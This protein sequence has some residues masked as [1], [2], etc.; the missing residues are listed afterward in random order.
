MRKSMAVLAVLLALAILVLCLSAIGVSAR[1]D[2]VI[3]TEETLYGSP[4]S[5]G[6]LRLQ[7]TSAYDDH[8]LWETVFH[9]AEAEAAQT[10]FQFV[11]DLEQEDTDF[12]AFVYVEVGVLNYSMHFN[13]GLAEL[14]AME[15]GED[16]HSAVDYALMLKPAID[17]ASRTAAG[18]TRKETL[19]LRDYYEYY[20]VGAESHIAGALSS[21]IL[22]DADQ[23]KAQQAHLQNLIRFPVPEDATVEVTVSK[24][25][26]GDVYEINSDDHAFSF[27]G[28][29]LSA[30]TKDALYG[31]LVYDREIGIDF[32]HFPQGNGIYRVPIE[33]IGE[34]SYYAALEQM[35]NVYPVQ[36]DVLICG[37]QVSD[38][39][40]QLLLFTQE[41]D[42]FFLTVLNRNTM[43]PVQQMSF[44]AK[45]KP[46]VWC[47]AETL[48]LR[49]TSSEDE[50]PYVRVYTKQKNGYELWTETQICDMLSSHYG[51]IPQLVF[52]GEKLAVAN[53][54]D[55]WGTS[56]C[57][58]QVIGQEE[59]LYAG[60]FHHNAD[61]IAHA[62][63][64]RGANRLT[65]EWVGN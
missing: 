23:R 29:E 35:E 53:L 62:P 17:V 42:H 25:A 3:L 47:S 16:H 58:L 5:V 60:Y 11:Q 31:M 41:Q 28:M 34:G 57:W 38:D 10:Q 43:E 59:L 44:A 32:Q 54:T 4:D 1:Q 46:E 45:N 55:N 51:V 15:N 33:Q 13:D 52:N 63:G 24:Y 48:V 12:Y 64:N 7:I 20:K 50:N 14:E 9:P 6:D 49:Y 61:R 22:P 18:E 21:Q 19:R 56:S 39:E 27:K 8:L 36:P 2:A 26:K 40:A 37:V 65:L 30:C